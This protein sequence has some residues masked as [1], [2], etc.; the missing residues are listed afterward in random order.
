MDMWNKPNISG[1]CSISS[2]RL[3][4]D[5]PTC[6]LELETL[7]SVPYLSLDHANLGQPP[8]T[9]LLVISPG[10]YLPAHTQSFLQLWSHDQCAKWQTTSGNNNSTLQCVRLHAFMCK[11]GKNEAKIFLL[12][13]TLKIVFSCISSLIQLEL[14]VLLDTPHVMFCNWSKGMTESLPQPRHSHLS[15]CRAP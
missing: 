6:S 8:S 10:I 11:N 3:L 15:P 1:K 9:R 4:H 12:Y 5:D 14:S 2:A 7:L 13:P